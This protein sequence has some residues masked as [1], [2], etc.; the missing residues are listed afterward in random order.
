MS[1][2][3]TFGSGAAVARAFNASRKYFPECAASWLSSDGVTWRQ[4]DPFSGF[5]LDVALTPAGLIGVGTNSGLDNFNGPVAWTSSDGSQWSQTPDVPGSATAFLGDIEPFAG[6]WV[7]IG[8]DGGR[9]RV[10]DA[11][12]IPLEGYTWPERFLVASTRFEFAEVIPGLADV[13]YFADPDGHL[14]EIAWNPSFRVK[15]DG[16]IVLPD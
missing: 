7:A 9:S 12:G 8:A 15:E 5:M 2:T 14:W 13:S 11:L 10:R 4:V 3:S 6:G 1:T 16:A